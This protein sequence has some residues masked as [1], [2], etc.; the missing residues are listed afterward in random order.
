ML[1]EIGLVGLGVMGKNIAL[2]LS[3]KGVTIKSFN[4]S[5]KKLDDIKK[6]FSNEFIGYTILK[7]L[8]RA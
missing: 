7:N 3:D 5:M 6:E 2:N 4:D 8:L 1:N